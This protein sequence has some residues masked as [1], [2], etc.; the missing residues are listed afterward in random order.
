M[1]PWPQRP[2]CARF[3][4]L[5]GPSR[6]A[7]PTRRFSSTTNLSATWECCR[8]AA[9]QMHSPSDAANEHERGQTIRC[10]ESACACAC[11]AIKRVC[12]VRTCACFESHMHAR[13]GAFLLERA[14][15]KA[16]MYHASSVQTHSRAC[17]Q[18]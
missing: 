1:R 10:S 12:I 18:D 14:S 15:A 2:T 8:H 5:C 16:G 7:G 4:R 11:A 9:M 3:A 6:R 17:L 13:M